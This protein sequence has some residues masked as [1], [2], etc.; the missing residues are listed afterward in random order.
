MSCMT[1]QLLDGWSELTGEPE[2]IKTIKGFRFTLFRSLLTSFAKG[3][4]GLGTL[5][6]VFVK[7][8]VFF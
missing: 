8:L 2:E 1:T 3:A 5:A 6:N 4:Q 7:I